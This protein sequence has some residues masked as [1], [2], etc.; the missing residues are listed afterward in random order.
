MSSF[1]KKLMDLRV[2]INFGTTEARSS[3]GLMTIQPLSNDPPSQPPLSSP[4]RPSGYSG[5]HRSILMICGEQKSSKQA[6]DAFVHFL[7]M[8]ICNFH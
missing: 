6:N 8:N 4:F 3:A 2:T 7:R 1:Y 5:G